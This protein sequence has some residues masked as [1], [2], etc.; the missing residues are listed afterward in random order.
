MVGTFEMKLAA[1]AA[2]AVPAARNGRRAQSVFVW[3]DLRCLA[4]TLLHDFVNLRKSQPRGFVAYCGT[5]FLA[6]KTQNDS[7]LSIFPAL[8]HVAISPPK[9]LGPAWQVRTSCFFGDSILS[10]S[11]FW[12]SCTGPSIG[13]DHRNKLKCGLI[14]LSFW[15]CKR[16][17]HLLKP[18]KYVL[19]SGV[20]KMLGGSNSITSNLKFTRGLHAL[21]G[22]VNHG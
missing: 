3:A 10:E 20:P 18:D 8:H 1:V 14:D 5:R 16:H 7:G 17:P 12:Q 6:G 4:Q 22:K 2:L 11:V 9:V 13:Q 15:L 19:F 21:I